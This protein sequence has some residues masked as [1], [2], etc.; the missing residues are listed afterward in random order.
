MEGECALFFKMELQM[1]KSI[2]PRL[3]KKCGVF[4]FPFESAKLCYVCAGL[5]PYR[6]KAEDKSF[7]IA[8]LPGKADVVCDQETVCSC[9]K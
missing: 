5:T 6:R 8:S 7:K 9:T 3:C 2:K 4:L 1:S